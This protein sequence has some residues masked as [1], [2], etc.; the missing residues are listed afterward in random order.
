MREETADWLNPMLAE[1]DA[2]NIDTRALMTQATMPAAETDVPWLEN[3][4]ESV[5]LRGFDW[6]R[7]GQLLRHELGWDETYP[8]IPDFPEARDVP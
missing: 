3:A 5:G 7:F 6:V 4:P 8:A 1:V 2:R